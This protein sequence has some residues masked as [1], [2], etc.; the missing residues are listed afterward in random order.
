LPN[1]YGLARS[2]RTGRRIAGAR[3]QARYDD[4]GV[5]DVGTSGSLP[6]SVYAMLR[7]LA[8]ES[9]DDERTRRNLKAAPRRLHMADSALA[10]EW[11]ALAAVIAFYGLNGRRLTLTN[12]EAYDLV[13]SVA[14]GQLDD[15]D[16]IA[17]VL[18]NA[19]QP[20]R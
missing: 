4:G 9:L 10:V 15:A 19:T 20:R 16:A 1:Q 3:W 11:L 18:R 17:A 5:G 13:I 6:R 7:A 8:G 14:A 12:D 2:L